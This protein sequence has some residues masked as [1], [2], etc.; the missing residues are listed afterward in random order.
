[1]Q[2]SLVVVLGLCIVAACLPTEHSFGSQA[3]VVAAQGLISFSL[4]PG[5]MDSEVV[6]H[7][8]SRSTADGVFTDQG[9]NPCPLH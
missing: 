4:W 7:G 1:M 3:S 8:L 6:A 5:S 2:V 9:L